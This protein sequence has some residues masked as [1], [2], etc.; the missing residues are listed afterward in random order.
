MDVLSSGE[1]KANKEHRCSLCGGKIEK[2]EVYQYAKIRGDELYAWKSH[3]KC[4]KLVTVLHMS[5]DGDGISDSDFCDYVSDALCNLKLH[6][7]VDALIYALNKRE[8]RNNG[9]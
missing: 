1:R 8:E 6:E 7:K 9:K 4:E 2:G 5:D 3:V